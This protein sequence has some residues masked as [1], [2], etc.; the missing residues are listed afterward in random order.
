MGRAPFKVYVPDKQITHSSSMAPSKVNGFTK[1]V[2]G[3]MLSTLVKLRLT[4]FKT[5][6]FQ[7]KVANR[8]RGRGNEKVD[9]DIRAVLHDKVFYEWY[10]HK[11]RQ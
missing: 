8:K 10:C 3:R 2:T 4:P 1:V 5:L 6:K 9:W 7:G 11:F